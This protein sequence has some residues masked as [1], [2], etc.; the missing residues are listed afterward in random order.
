MTCMT[1]HNYTRR[2]MIGKSRVLKAKCL[3]V[4]GSW[5]HGR[6]SRIAAILRIGSD[7]SNSYVDVPTVGPPTA[8]TC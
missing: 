1:E 8:I 3:V 4:Y 7:Q 6:G 2:S 5:E